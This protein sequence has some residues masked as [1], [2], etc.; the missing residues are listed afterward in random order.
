[1]CVRIEA[2]IRGDERARRK[3]QR[4]AANADDLRPG[5][6]KVL[7][8]LRDEEIR[9]FGTRG[10]GKWP[11]NS[12]RTIARKGGDTPLIDEGWLNHALTRQNARGGVSRRTRTRAVFGVNDRGKLFYARMVGKRRPFIVPDDR[13]ERIAV[14]TLIE[15]LESE[16]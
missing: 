8:R 1:M 12:P 16:N 6:D 2:W 4:L 5:W 3:L 9:I 13:A 15:H 14:R 7:G 10:Y 11:A